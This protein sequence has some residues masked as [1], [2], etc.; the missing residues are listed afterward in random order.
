VW[1][2]FGCQIRVIRAQFS[3]LPAAV[4]LGLEKAVKIRLKIFSALQIV[5][6]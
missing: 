6:R 3:S 2:Y 1:V 5:K 4:V